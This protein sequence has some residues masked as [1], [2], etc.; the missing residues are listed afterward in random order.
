ML[1]TGLATLLFGLG[2]ALAAPVAHADT[3][4]FDD[5][6]ASNGVN[7]ST[8]AM[9][10]SNHDLG[11]S[12]C[13]LFSAHADAGDSGRTTRL[14]AMDLMSGS[15]NGADAATW[16]VASVNYLCPRYESMLG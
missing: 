2:A 13:N 6:L 15:T 1:K 10:Q 7:M 9:V 3:A 5:Y 12:I 16:V 11:E 14:D 8:P 4:A